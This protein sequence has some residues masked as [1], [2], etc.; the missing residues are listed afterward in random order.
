MSCR[1]IDSLFSTNSNKLVAESRLGIP[2]D[3]WPQEVFKRLNHPLGLTISLRMI[4][5]TE[6][7]ICTEQ[8][9]DRLPKLSGKMRIVVRSYH[10]WEG[11]VV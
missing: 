6:S 8:V 4:R 11:Y 5:C 7:Q 3:V 2:L 10:F 9:K 1:H